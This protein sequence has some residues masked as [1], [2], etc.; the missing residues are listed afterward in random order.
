M[1]DKLLKEPSNPS[2]GL[3]NLKDNTQSERVRFFN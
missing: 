2:V 1:I 3:K